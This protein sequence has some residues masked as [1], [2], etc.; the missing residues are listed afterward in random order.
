VSEVA[1]QPERSRKR[2]AVG[3]LLVVCVIWGSTFLLMEAGTDALRDCYGAEPLANGAHFLAVRFVLAAVAMP[4]LLPGCLRVD[5]AAWRHGFWLSVVFSGAFL[6]QIYGLGQDD[7]RP[8][9][10]A[11]LT[12]LYVVATPLLAAV[13][14]RRMPPLGVLLGV[15]L[16]VLGAAFIAGPPTGGLS[17][18]AW[19]TL[20]CAVLFGAQILMTDYSSR[21]VAPAVLTFTMLALSALWMLLA[22]VVAPG[23]AARLASRSMLCPL[24]SPV[25][26]GTELVCA[27]LATVLVVW[28]FNRWQ[29]E[30][31]PSRAALIYTTEPVF[32]AV[33]SIAAGRDRVT[34]WLLFGS[35]MI[36]AANLV[37]ELAGTRKAASSTLREPGG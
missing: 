15:P 14:H 22:L 20:A 21:R 18:G 8:S 27:L 13:L 36:L 29:K 10:S 5:R 33:I 24:S 12:S 3:A 26:V 32:A 2:A 34:G 1:A 7:V 16:A 9:Q 11:Y 6:L 28:L 19:A 31:H 17:A 30:L 35:A 25:F 4:L 37:A 23:G